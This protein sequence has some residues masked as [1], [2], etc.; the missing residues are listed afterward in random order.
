MA[1]PLAPALPPAPRMFGLFVALALSAAILLGGR[2]PD[3][4]ELFAFSWDKLQ[5]ALAYAVLAGAWCVAFGGRRAVLAILIAVA[6]GALDEWLQRALPGRQADLADL[7]ADA[8]G[9]TIGAWLASMFAARLWQRLM[10]VA[11]ARG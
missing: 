11:A 9:A 6:T 4:V 8:I 3:A 10:G 5:H 2:V 7:L 1:L